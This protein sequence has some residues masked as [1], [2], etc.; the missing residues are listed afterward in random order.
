VTDVT[1]APGDHLLLHFGA[2]DWQ[3]AVFVNGIA[4]GN[5]TG[6]FDSFSLDITSALKT[7]S[8]VLHKNQSTSQSAND[9]KS[10]NKTKTMI[11]MSIMRK[12]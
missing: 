12:L 7:G 1:V 3:C 9:E 2:V 6:G 5:H 4:V 8:S 11:K 10:K